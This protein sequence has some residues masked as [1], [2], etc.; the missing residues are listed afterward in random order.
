MNK[1]QSHGRSS[2][3]GRLSASSIFK[4]VAIFF[5]VFI[6][7]IVQ[8][9]FFLSFRPF[10]SAPDLCLALV[11][12]SALRWGAKKGAVVG[13]LAGFCL[14]CFAKVGFSLLIPFYFLIAI[15][16]A[17]FFEDTN[18]RGFPIFFAAMSVSMIARITLTFFEICL[19]SSSFAVGKVVLNVL[20]PNFLIS[21]I[22][23][24]IIYFTVRLTDRVFGRRENTKR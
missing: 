21:L 10:G 23:S 3:G 7:A 1:D 4:Y 2:E 15:A 13:I 9:G 18:A 6:T 16:I 24:P 14:D 5:A 22:F 8:S 17:L 11:I 12:A 19:S 20:L